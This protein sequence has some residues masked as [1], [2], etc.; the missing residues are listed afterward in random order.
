M[1]HKLTMCCPAS[2]ASS[3][4][5]RPGQIQRRAH[6]FQPFPAG[7]RMCVPSTARCLHAMAGAHL[8]STSCKIPATCAPC[9]TGDQH[10][11]SWRTGPAWHMRL[12]NA[13]SGC[14]QQAEGNK[15][16]IPSISGL[17]CA[18]MLVAAAGRERG[19]P[20]PPPPS[21]WRHIRTGKRFQ[22][23]FDVASARE[24]IHDV[25]MQAIGVR[26]AFGGCSAAHKRTRRTAWRICSPKIAATKLA[27]NAHGKGAG[28]GEI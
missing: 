16:R 4:T 1:R 9:P 19:P 28:V 10:L 17:P 3:N 12:T 5:S 6:E 13:T 18:E 21:S 20:T 7:P 26:R 25:R 27:W 23:A 11:F 22:C 2:E 14:P 15:T 24:R 8:E